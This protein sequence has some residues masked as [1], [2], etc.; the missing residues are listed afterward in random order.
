LAEWLGKWFSVD[1]NTTRPYD[2]QLLSTYD[3]L[4]LKTPEEAIPDEEVAAIDRFVHRG[5]GL[6][7]VGDH[8]NLLGMGT[9]LNSLRQA[10]RPFSP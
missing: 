4:V 3:V 1:V 7:L 5:G 2:D 10:R 8:T 9:H 6:L